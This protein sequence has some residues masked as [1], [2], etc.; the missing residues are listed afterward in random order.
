MNAA[1]LAK[2]RDGLQRSIDEQR[3]RNQLEIAAGV[4]QIERMKRDLWERTGHDH[5]AELRRPPR[6]GTD[7]NAARIEEGE[8]NA[9]RWIADA[10]VLWAVNDRLSGTAVA[11]VI[12]NREKRAP[13]QIEHVASIVRRHRPKR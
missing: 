6:S 9:E 12:C 1:E 5:D 8:A 11:K 4:A 3:Q 10:R 2:L 13:S 7:A